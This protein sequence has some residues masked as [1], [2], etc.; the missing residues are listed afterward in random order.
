MRSLKHD[1]AALWLVVFSFSRGLVANAATNLVQVIEHGTTSYVFSPT[2]LTINPGD[3]VKWTN[4]V[5][6]PHD[7][8]HRPTN[9]AT[10]WQSAKFSNSPPV[11]S[12]SFTFSNAG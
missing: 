6:N 11:T 9:G 2:N 8:T 1:C 7:S 5:A 10:L 4:T 3:T 12:F